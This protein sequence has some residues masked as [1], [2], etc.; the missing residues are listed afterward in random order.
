MESI[1]KKNKKNKRDVMHPFIAKIKRLKILK[2]SDISF[3]DSFSNKIGIDL[4]TAS[5]VVSVDGSGVV[6]H[7]PTL[8]AINK[9]T[10]QIIAIG[11][12]ARVMIGRTP[13]HISVERPLQDGVV[14]NYEIAEQMLEYIFREVQAKNPKILGP[15]VTIGVPCQTTQTEISAVKDAA[16]D[17]GAREV[18]IVYEPFAAAVGIGGIMK[19][20]SASMVIDVGGG[21]SD[22]IVIASG[23]I[24][25]TGSLRLAGSTFDKNI[26]NGLKE[27]KNL[28][29]GERTAEDLKM[30][31]MSTARDGGVFSVH[32]RNATVGL[33]LEVEV[34]FEEVLS[35]IKPSMET[36]AQHL[37]DFIETISPEILA[38]LKNGKVYFV[39]GG[40][41][42]NTFSKI[43][44]DKINLMLETPEDHMVVVAK[45]ASQIAKNS[46]E[47]QKYF[48]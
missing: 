4:G 12:N 45:G 36:I 46:E 1:I 44:G 28:L 22:A 10:Q 32:G 42:I 13:E 27:Y 41:F 33:P 39:G 2:L 31:T 15:N 47:Y 30:A 14:F 24:I 25:A 9:K 21:T 29:V 40:P 34:E 43:I 38:D 20:D 5:T 11:K 37:K 18:N 3:F 6:I 48:L 8:V 35:Y 16:L 26:L 19:K 23:E 17:A 7:E